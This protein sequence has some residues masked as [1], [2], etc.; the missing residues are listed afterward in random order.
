MTAPAHAPT[1]WALEY[2][3]ID[4]PFLEKVVDA[5]GATIRVK[6]FA[7]SQGDEPD[8]NAEFIVRAVNAHEQM[9]EALLDCQA[10][11]RG[12]ISGPA[13]RDGIARE[14]DAAITAATSPPT[15]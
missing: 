11:L 5:K 8:A 14:I 15:E 3:D 12:D 4:G 10:L 13:Q 9:L 1:P 7:L 2:T 6:G